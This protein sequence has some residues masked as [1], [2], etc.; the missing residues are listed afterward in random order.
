MTAAAVEETVHECPRGHGPMVK[1]PAEA[2]SKE[3]AFCGT[4]WDCKNGCASSAL[5]PSDRFLEWFITEWPTAQQ[6]PIYRAELERRR[7]A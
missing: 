7:S 1:R 3:Q 6:T 4:W 5:V 2:M